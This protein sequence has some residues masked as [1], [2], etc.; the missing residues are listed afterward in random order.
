MELFAPMLSCDR[1]VSN[2][3][4]CM[5]MPSHLFDAAFDVKGMEISIQGMQCH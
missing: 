4:P 2:G 3:L 1:V 5:I